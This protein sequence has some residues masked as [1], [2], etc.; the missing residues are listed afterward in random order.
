MFRGLR[1]CGL[2]RPENLFWLDSGSLCIVQEAPSPAG[3]QF[4]CLKNYGEGARRSLRP[5][6]QQLLFLNSTKRWG[7]HALQVQGRVG[8][9][10]HPLLSA[11]LTESPGSEDCVARVV[12]FEPPPTHVQDSRAQ[13]SF[14]SKHLGVQGQAA[15]GGGPVPSRAPGC[16]GS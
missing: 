13:R 8:D 15:D 11:P 3:P 5:S 16:R 7:S 1:V 4:P 10:A 2:C 9:F 14:Q 12:P 6:F